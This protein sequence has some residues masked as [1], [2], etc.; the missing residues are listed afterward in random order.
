M[1]FVRPKQI[2]QEGAALNQVLTWDGSVWAPA[3]TSDSETEAQEAVTSQNITGTDTA[4]TDT[5]DNTPVSNAAVRLFLNG[6]LQKQGATFD[7]TIAGDTITWL[8]SSG[9]AVD[10]DTND[11]L[12]AV[13]DY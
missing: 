13:Y 4:L 8:A 9:S 2:A 1:S 5:L 3:N 12:V 10:M 6:V 7:Y 11:E